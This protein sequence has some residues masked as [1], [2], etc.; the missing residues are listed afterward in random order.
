MGALFL[1]LLIFLFG[2]NQ[3]KKVENEVAPMLRISVV[4]PNIPQSV[5]WAAMAKKDVIE[6]HENLTKLA[7]MR[8]P[9]LVVWFVLPINFASWRIYYCSQITYHLVNVCI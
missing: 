6:I 3:L 4:Q 9:D 2:R 7:A 8:E 1:I 5:K